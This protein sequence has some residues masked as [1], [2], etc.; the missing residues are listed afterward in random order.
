MFSI[1]TAEIRWFIPGNIPENVSVWLALQKGTREEQSP[2]SDLY[3]VL[4]GQDSLGIKLREGRIEIKKRLAIHEDLEAPGITGRVE[5]WIKWSVKAEDELTPEH[6]LSH[7]PSHWISINKKRCLQKYEIGDEGNLMPHR[8]EGFP[9]EGIA[10]EL[11]ELN[12]GDDSWWTFGLECFGNSEQVYPDLMT[13]IPSLTDGF[14]CGELIHSRSSGYPE[15][16]RR[17][18]I[19]KP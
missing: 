11:S 18:F 7:D 19:K 1:A 2:R 14:P 13:F 16:I 4:P 8:M 10:V 15:W 6:L 17:T 9:P 12:A 3:L 5:S